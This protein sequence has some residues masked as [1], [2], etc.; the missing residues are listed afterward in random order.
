MDQKTQ[1]QCHKDILRY[2]QVKWAML[3]PHSPEDYDQL[4][5]KAVKIR[6]DLFELMRKDLRFFIMRNL[7][8]WGRHESDQELLAL[9]WETF[10]FAMYRYRNY[11]RPLMSHFSK[12]TRYFLLTHYGK[13]DRVFLPIDELQDILSDGSSPND[14]HFS[15]LMDICRYRDSLPSEY[16]TVFDDAFFSLHPRSDYHRRSPDLGGF[17]EAVYKHLRKAFETTIRFLIPLS[18]KSKK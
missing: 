9:S 16:H 2:K 18:F 7:A 8:N 1:K 13:K 14:M 10:R 4:D 5:D 15:Q 11:E 6:N 12:M 17:S 3:L